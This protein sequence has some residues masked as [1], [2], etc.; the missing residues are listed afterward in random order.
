MRNLLSVLFAICVA[1][2]TTLSASGDSH[3]ASKSASTHPSN[4]SST[5]STS[6]NSSSTQSSNSS[7]TQSTSSNSSSSH[8]SSSASQS[9]SN[10]Y[11]TPNPATN[12]YLKSNIYYQQ[13]LHNSQL[14][15]EK[16]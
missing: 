2:G 10:R 4:S 6:S 3:S 12:P 5:K 14:G 11:P 1:T 15:Q 9:S 8:S 7:S 13:L 16:T